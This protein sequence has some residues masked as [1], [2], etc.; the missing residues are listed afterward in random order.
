MRVNP[1]DIK[2][3]LLAR[4]AQH[5]VLIH[6][7]IALFIVAVAFDYVAQRKKNRSLAAAAYFNLLFA[8]ISTVPVVATGLAAWQWALEGQKLK[9]ILLMHL[10]LGC[11]SSVLIWVVFLIHWR[12]RRRDQE[13]LPKYR[14][15]IE[16]IAVLIIVLTGHLGGFLSGVNGPG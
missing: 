13:S 8:A 1:F 16:A 9:G 4:H 14:L 6:F 3:L 10:V 15:V 2:T 7:P 11:T 12:A 5:V